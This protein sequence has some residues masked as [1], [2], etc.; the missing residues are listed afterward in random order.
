MFKFF[1]RK[2]TKEKLQI[3]YNT[4]IK[5]AYNLSKTNRSQSDIKYFE[6]DLLLKEIDKLDN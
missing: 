1:K 6:A 5:Q 4:L 2:T 3:K